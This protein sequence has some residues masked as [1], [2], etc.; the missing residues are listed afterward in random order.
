MNLKLKRILSLIIVVLFLFTSVFSS[1]ITAENGED[2]T[3][4][5]VTENESSDGESSDD[6]NKLPAVFVKDGGA[7]TNDGKSYSAPFATLEAAV[8]ALSETGGI[9]VVCG[10]LSLTDERAFI[11]A[12]Q[13]D[14]EIT[15]YYESIDYRAQYDA[16][17]YITDTL[18]IYGPA[19][20]SFYGIRIHSEK[21]SNIFCN[22]SN[23]VF[24]SKIEN[25]TDS[26]DY[27]SIWGGKMLKDSDSVKDGSFS[28][29]SLQIDSGYWDRVTLGNYRI[30]KFSPLSTISNGSLNINGGTFLSE[31][32]ANTSSLCSG[33]FVSGSMSLHITG[34]IFYGSFYVIGNEGQVLPHIDFKYDADI[35]I[36][37]TNGIFMGEYLKAL[38]SDNATLYGTFDL[39]ILGGSFS[40]LTYIGCEGVYSD[41]TL[42]SFDEI[43]SKLFGFEKVVFVDQAN[44]NDKNGGESPATAKAT[45]SNAITSLV[46]GGTVVICSKYDLPDGFVMTYNE[47]PIKITAK[48]SDVDYLESNGA[49]LTL[50]GN[51]NIQSDITF[52]NITL[53]ASTDTE[54]FCQ[55]SNIV[56]SQNCIVE[57][58]VG[59]KLSSSENNRNLN[60]ASGKFNY[61]N[62]GTSASLTSFSVTGGELGELRFDRE[63]PHNGDILIDLSAGTI[64]G[65]INMS[66]VTIVGNT[67]IILLNT[68]VSGN[69]IAPAPSEGK[70]CEALVL[71]QNAIDKLNGFTLINEKYVFVK[72]G[73]IG[74]GSTPS[75]AAPDLKTAYA[76][77]AENN[78]I[79]VI[80][81]PYTH[82]DEAEEI[83]VGILTYTSVYKCVDY[84]KV[85][86]AS[87][88]LVS[89]FN[90]Y[91]DATVKNVVIKTKTHSTSFRCNSHIVLFDYGITCLTTFLTAD[92]YPSIY[93]A[94]TTPVMPFNEKGESISDKITL[95]GGTWYNIYSSAATDIHGS[96][97]MGSFYGTDD[98]SN[99]ASI[100]ISNG[101]IYGGVYAAKAMK[102]NCTSS[103]TIS[104][105][106]GEIHGLISPSYQAATG[107][108]GR[109][110]INITGGDFSAVDK[111]VGPSH[112]GAEKFYANVDVTYDKEAGMDA[113]S[114]YNN[115]IANNRNSLQ[116]FDGYW[117][118]FTVSEDKIE[119]RRSVSV[120][121]LHSKEAYTTIETGND[122]LDISLSNLNGKIYIFVRNMSD[123]VHRTRV[124]LSQKTDN[125]L[126]F[127][128]FSD[129]ERDDIHSPALYSLN[130]QNYLYYSKQNE[131]NG[132][133]ICCVMLKD[134]M[135]FGTDPI[136][137][138][139]A[140]ERWENGSV[141]TPII[142][143]TQEGKK[144]LVYSGGDIFSGGSMIGIAMISDTTDLVNSA[145]YQ[146]CKDPVF[147][148]NETHKD[149]VLSSIISITDNEPYIVFTSNI[150]GENVLVMQSFSYDIE[151][152]PYFSDP[153]DI[154]MRYLAYNSQRSFESL[155]EGYEINVKANV[156]TGSII[157]Q[158]F[159]FKFLKT[160]HFVIITCG[161]IGML[162]VLAIVLI[163][164]FI[165]H[166]DP[167]SIKNVSNKSNKLD[168]RHSRRRSGKLYAAYLEQNSKIN[169]D[170]TQQSLD[171]TDSFEKDNAES[172]SMILIKYEKDEGSNSQVEAENP[173]KET[174]ID[175]NLM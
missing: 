93:A 108:N 164:K 48:Y 61:V 37:I 144:Y 106:G 137:V 156:D 12:H 160:E 89:T 31:L 107:Y 167:S 35:K 141:G 25:V 57:G 155:L 124:F 44:G 7:D 83:K 104:I 114:S 11:P 139:S 159:S 173:S 71:T 130:G 86:N 150:N 32:E 84:S 101:I 62:L 102:N 39:A 69:I 50:S 74:D 91:N 9:I 46:K 128:H 100:V 125:S 134:N 21:K 140:T 36:T 17:I 28:D 94:E 97:I 143:T 126:S 133:D 66:N 77:A 10:K 47:N 172:D 82:I 56:F 168:R 158:P 85:N 116:Y 42:T 34:G 110:T 60:I 105:S 152:V 26:Q 64:N 38:Y 111:F 2:K 49:K 15:S 136:K 174:Q 161:L 41:I 81:G 119:V 22:G 129:I 18:N 170:E 132:F 162:L 54:L 169:F 121:S 78:A 90:F 123:G 151:G 115:P 59:I 99:N 80:C 166:P 30:D 122:I 19:K 40:S 45:L 13:S 68:E 109:Y 120:M 52:E 16:E 20:T 147:Y 72:D 95:K 87:L 127:T 6:S 70:V 131:E 148:Q 135:Q 79:V 145:M 75:L 76:A 117:Y 5:K 4:N 14:I 163:K 153:C 96:I 33:S 157:K 175:D 24:G 65:D 149:L 154:N 53:S 118:L 67:Q 55:C 8:S 98:L 112:V 23:V 165:I 51:I 43:Q 138:I 142:Y 146:K 73:G 103:V 3:D 1:V 29:F 63:N 113:L 27:P 171:K 58:N 92:N 88:N